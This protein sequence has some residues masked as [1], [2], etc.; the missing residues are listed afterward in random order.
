MQVKGYPLV[1]VDVLH[2]LGSPPAYSQYSHTILLH[3]YH[4]D[5]LK[6][7]CFRNL[8]YF[9]LLTLTYY[10]Q[11]INTRTYKKLIELINNSL[12]KPTFI[13]SSSLEGLLK[14]I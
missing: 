5:V 7:K 1:W 2:S 10:L 12:I 11:H 9:K 14:N 13:V 4:L 8:I 6:N 3:K